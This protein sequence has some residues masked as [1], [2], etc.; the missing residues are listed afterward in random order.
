M[1]ASMVD[2]ASFDFAR[3]SSANVEER[4]GLM[5]GLDEELA[6]SS[7]SS[8]SELRQLRAFLSQSITTPF[9]SSRVLP[10][11]VATTEITAYSCD[12]ISLLWKR[13]G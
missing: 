8:S 1:T 11:P 7:G 9:P 2:L 5:P 6:P 13:R 10:K 4:R 3:V 12:V